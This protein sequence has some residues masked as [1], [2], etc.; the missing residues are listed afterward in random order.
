MQPMAAGALPAGACRALL[1]VARLGYYRGV[2]NQLQSLQVQ[3]PECAAFIAHQE[4]LARQYQFETM[5]E[6]L[7][8]VLDASPADELR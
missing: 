6:Q 4:A 2:L 5:A 7:Q 3:H 8:K 1:E